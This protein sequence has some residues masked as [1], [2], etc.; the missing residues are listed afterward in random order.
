[1]I[2]AAILGLLAAL[3]LSA[4]ERD[5]RAP[6][7]FEDG[8]PPRLSDWRI[9]S[10]DGDRLTPAQ[11]ST[12]YDLATPLFSDYAL[13]YRTVW[14][15]NGAQATY[16]ENEVFDFPVGSIITKTFYYPMAEA[17]WTG[18]VKIGSP[19]TSQDSALALDGL[20]LIETRL[21]VKRS[22]GWV[23]IPYVWNDEQSDAALKR[24]GDIKPLTLIHN[25]GQREKFAYLVPNQN[26]CAGCHATNASTRE[27]SPIGPKARHLNKPSSYAAGVN[28]LNDWKARGVLTAGF[29]THTAPR[30][31]IW[32]D[33]TAS[34]DDRARAYLDANCTHC[35][36]P[37]G[38]ADTSG[39]NF[40][41][42]I[43]LGPAAGLCKSP[44]AAGGGSGGR[45]FDIVPGAPEKSITV[46]RMETTDP[47]A[48]MPELGRAVAH[49]EGVAL[50]A[51]WIASMDGDCG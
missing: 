51:E 49:Q 33:K 15:P 22:D 38:P 8:Y 40:E 24:T 39:L 42:H 17:G 6:V 7:F 50:V 14:M 37:V 16:R 4:C 29:D 11:G 19:Q 21:L 10:V 3:A 36:S 5:V 45:P 35:H 46:F 1:M 28:Q 41:P 31:A 30:N 47:G 12:P 13:K 43:E 34:L 20:R 23:A 32:T 48:M 9:L 27:L 44:I 26:Q 25:D 2:K 18:A